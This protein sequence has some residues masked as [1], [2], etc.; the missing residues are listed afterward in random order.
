MNQLQNIASLEQSPV[1][2]R[3][4][5]WPAAVLCAMLATTSASAQTIQGTIRDQTSHQPVPGATVT[6]LDARDSALKAAVAS[7]TGQFNIT[8]AGGGVIAINVRSIGYTELTTTA[9]R[10]G[11]GDTV[12]LELQLAPTAVTL[13]TVRAKATNDSG[14]FFK[15][16]PG[17]TVFE[18]HAALGKGIFI[19]GAQL[20]KS[21]MSLTEYLGHEPGVRL[22]GMAPK[23]VPVIPGSNGQFLVSDLKSQCLYA[24][25]DHWSVLS[26]LI[27]HH[28]A[29]IDQIAEV[30]DVMGVEFYHNISEVPAEWRADAALT[31]VWSRA[32]TPYV[33]ADRYMIGTTEHLDRITYQ[34]MDRL[35]GYRAILYPTGA[36]P[37]SVCGF[38]Q[39][40]TKVS[41]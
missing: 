25:I 32:Y 20:E 12:T 24:R 16:T 30:K 41:W 22:A 36:V 17:H 14:G 37:I 19:S 35:S 10:V 39:V 28:A 9:A 1:V 34:T 8:I 11:V 15:V 26:L 23:D 31:E 38:M 29:N 7:K 33:D 40:W 2:S 13:D 3:R 27:Q 4:H 18:R 21:G 6:I 5:R